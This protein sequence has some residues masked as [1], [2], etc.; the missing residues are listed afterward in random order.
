[1]AKTFGAEFPERQLMSVISDL[2]GI[3]HFT[4][5]R[6]STVRTDFLLA[7]GAGLGVNPSELTGIKKDEVLAT[8][9]Q[10]ATR[11]PMPPDLLSPGGTVTNRALQ[12]IVDGIMRHGVPGKWTPPGVAPAAG[13]FEVEPP[14]DDLSEDFDPDQVQDARDRRLLATAVRQGQDRFRTAVLEAYSYKCAVTKFDAVDA[15]QAAHIFPYRGPATNAVTNGLCLRADIHALF[16][17]GALSVHEIDY[18]LILKPHLMVTRYADLQDVR[19]S[20]PSAKHLRPSSAAL[21]S[22]REWSG[23]LD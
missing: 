7:V 9:V 17:R 1:M 16:D 8:V 3:P 21:R 11:Q 13:E 15:L 20:V 6:G 10:A 18:R 4:T 12:L 19:L 23:L 2:L 22:H 5:A 14:T